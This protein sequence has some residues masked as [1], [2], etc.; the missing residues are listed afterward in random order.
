MLTSAE[1]DVLSRL[2]EAAA[3]QTLRE[4]V[5]MPSVGG[6]DGEAEIQAVLARRLEELGHAVDLWPLDLGQLR[7]A[8]GYPGEEV[9]RSEAWGLVGRVGGSADE[10]PW[11]ALG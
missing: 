3:V 6:T 7:A 2:D 8:A 11:L 10:K 4:L 5:A 1:A 9:E